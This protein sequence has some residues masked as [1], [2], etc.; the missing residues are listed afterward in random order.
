MFVLN[1]DISIGKFIGIKPIE[2]RLRKSLYEYIDKAIIKVP[3]TARIIQS[4]K[5]VT[6]STESAKQFSEGD[7]VLIKLGYNGRLYTEFEGFISRVNFTSPVELECEGYSYILKKRTYKRTFVKSQLIDILRYLVQDTEIVLDEKNIPSFVIDK[8]ILQ[9][10][11]GTEV[12]ELIKKLSHDTI[13]AN[14]SGNV[15]YAGLVLLDIRKRVNTIPDVKYRLGW[16]VV[17]DDNLKLREAKNQNVTVKF[18][19]I[20]KNGEIAEA[21]E[22]YILSPQKKTVKT[23]GKA[24]TDGE[25]K[26]VKTYTV[27]DKDALQK[28]AQEMSNKLSYTG[29]EGKIT[30]FLQPFGKPGDRCELEDQRYKERSGSYLVESTE[31]V[32]S[33]GGARRSVN[34]GIKL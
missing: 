19:G 11:S 18:L 16:N 10:H 24:G 23:V 7:K 26:V 17:K 2:V 8:L 1:S 32:Y 4:G 3:I 6:Q 29:Y 33:T 5:I 12:L 9:E 20:Q 13:Q 22:G 21:E 31:V 14:F 15:L 34:I 27:T 30:A 25:T 28:M